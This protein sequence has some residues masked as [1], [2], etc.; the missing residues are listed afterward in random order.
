[1]GARQTGRSFDIILGDRRVRPVIGRQ[2]ASRLNC[3]EAET[4]LE[5]HPVIDSEILAVEAAAARL[6]SSHAGEE[7]SEEKA[8]RLQSAVA[9]AVTHGK[10]I[11]DVAEAAH[12]TALEVLDAADAVTYAGPVANAP[13]AAL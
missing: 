10:S 12:L 5:D 7:N 8:A 1:M 3:N 13:S 11:K 6:E 2:N 4:E 9:T